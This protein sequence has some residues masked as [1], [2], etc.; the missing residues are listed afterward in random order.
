MKNNKSPVKKA[1]KTH[2]IGAVIYTGT[3]VSKKQENKYLMP[4][5][6]TT[7]SKKING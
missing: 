1:E 7:E 2:K 6:Y 5:G 4:D 3:F